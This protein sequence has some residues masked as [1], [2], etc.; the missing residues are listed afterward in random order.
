M[1]IKTNFQEKTEGHKWAIFRL[2]KLPVHAL[3]GLCTLNIFEYEISKSCRKFRNHHRE[4]LF[5][6]GNT[7]DRGRPVVGIATITKN[8]LGIKVAIACRMPAYAL[9]SGRSILRKKLNLEWLRLSTVWDFF[10]RFKYFKAQSMLAGKGNV[11][12]DSEKTS[13][14]PLPPPPRLKSLLQC[15]L[16]R[17]SRGQILSHW[18]G[19]KVASGIGLM[20]TWKLFLGS[21]KV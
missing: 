5:G 2:K 9:H 4:P 17:D 19:D 6:H 18:L 8:A 3:P 15:P 16:E 21:L 14:S 7:F 11:L 20:S 10:Q 12:F 13:H 1:Q